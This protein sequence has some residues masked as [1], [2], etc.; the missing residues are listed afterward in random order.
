MRNLILGL[1]CLLGLACGQPD[2][3]SQDPSIPNEE[4][5][6]HSDSGFPI[7]F[8]HVHPYGLEDLPKSRYV[9]AEA[10]LAGES[11]P[12]PYR[13]FLV[14]RD[15]VL[16]RLAADL[17]IPSLRE[18]VLS[19]KG[20]SV[21]LERHAYGILPQGPEFLVGLSD[22]AHFGEWKNH[23][24]GTGESL[25]LV[26][27]EEIPGDLPQALQEVYSV[28]RLYLF[29]FPSSGF[30]LHP[31]EIRDALEVEYL[32]DYLR[33]Y[34]E[35]FPEVQVTGLKAY[36]ADSGCWLMY[37]ESGRVHCGGVECGQV[38]AS[39]LT[40]EAVV[41][42]MFAQLLAGG[43]MNIESFAPAPEE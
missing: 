25:E 18:W 40:V 6:I 23:W 42:R 3:T 38:Y 30:F 27:P 19:L 37:D 14:H 11:F 29:G 10:G 32:G 21:V 2:G 5:V 41:E 31:S 20:R 17:S 15:S 9:T 36:Y 24:P 12:A 4:T 35:G 13:Q 43:R 28:G 33:D 26:M 8:A 1:G 22:W 34:A 16:D 7:S 39:G